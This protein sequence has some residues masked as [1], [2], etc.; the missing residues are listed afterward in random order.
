MNR[1]VKRIIVKF[2]SSLGYSIHPINKKYQN[3]AVELDDSDVDLI[4]YVFDRG[5]TMTN[6]P[7]L[8]ST[9][10]SCKYVVEN[11]ISGDFVECGVWRGGNGILA[12]R[13]FE[14]LDPQRRVWMF[15]TFEGMTAPTEYDVNTFSKIHS[16]KK[17][18]DSQRD[19]HND[20]CYAS[21]E[22]VQNNCINSDLK[23]DGISFIKGDVKKTLLV[24]DNLP[25][26]ISILR[27]DTDWYEEFPNHRTTVRVSG[28][29]V[30]KKQS[31]QKFNEFWSQL[32]DYNV[33]VDL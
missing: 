26:E 33:L 3:I 11:K 10:K 28:V 16:G 27:L 9:L 19:T 4:K 31:K 13:L 23:L 21:L 18:E 8:I 2:L 30:D 14:E 15:D 12:K 7:K 29:K 5:Y 24:K 6:V 1:L 20:W 25:R 22:D 17:F 32:V